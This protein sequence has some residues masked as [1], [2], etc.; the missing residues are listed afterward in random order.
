MNTVGRQDDDESSTPQKAAGQRDMAKQTGSSTVQTSQG[1]SQWVQPEQVNPQSS[2]E[3]QF[4]GSG[5]K[6]SQPKQ[7]Y[8]SSSKQK[9]NRADGAERDRPNRYAQPNRDIAYSQSN[10]ESSDEAIKIGNGRKKDPN[11]RYVTNENS[12]VG[13][14]HRSN[15][16]SISQS[17]ANKKKSASNSLN[18]DKLK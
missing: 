14:S 2:K 8:R 15:E 6:A 12:H 10:R 11:S 18:P 4:N 7:S 17:Q 13:V 5:K 1:V 3:V 16:A 9:D